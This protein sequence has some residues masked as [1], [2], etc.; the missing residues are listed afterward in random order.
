MLD[1]KFA[2]LGAAISFAGV[3]VYIWDTLHGETQPNRVSWL[4]WAVAPMV[5]FV[6]QLG[7]GVTYQSA[8]T[9]VSGFGPALVLAA[10]FVDRRAYWKITWS[11]LFCGVLSVGA[12]GIWLTLK[13]GTLTIAL[14]IIGDAFAALPTIIKSYRHPQ[15]ETASAFLLGIFAS[16]LT[17][18]TIST[19]TFANYGFALYLLLCDTLI[20]ILIRFPQWRLSGAKS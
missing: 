1:P 17:L 14:S 10:S 12:L 13:A 9:F 20:F 15:S 7:E 3:A 18:L 5:A 6:A 4:L 2:L 19:W 16:I 8:L 11:D